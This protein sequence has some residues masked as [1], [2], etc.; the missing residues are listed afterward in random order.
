MA[1]PRFQVV[2]TSSHMISGLGTDVKKIV[3][4][5]TAETIAYIG[6]QNKEKVIHFVKTISVECFNSLFAQHAGNHAIT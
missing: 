1:N 5:Y 4:T 2:S 6:E 3:D